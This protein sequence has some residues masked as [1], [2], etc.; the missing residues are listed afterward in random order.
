MEGSDPIVFKIYELPGLI[1][2]DMFSVLSNQMIILLP[3]LLGRHYL[4]SETG[5]RDLLFALL[6]GGVAYSIPALIEIR[7][8]PQLNT[9]IYGFFQHDFRQMMRNGGF[10]PIVFFPHALWL[11]FFFMGTAVAAAA[12]LRQE[13]R[14]QRVKY[15]FC[16]LYLLAVLVLSKSLASQ[17]Y[18]I[19]LVPLV[20]VANTRVQ[21]ALAIVLALLA[22][23]YPMLR[24]LG[25]IPL[26]AIL[27]QAEAVSPDRAQSLGYRFRN[28]EQLLDRARDKW[29]FGW[30][31]WGRN[32]VRH[33]ETGQ[34]LSIP[35]G[36]WIISFGS[37][38]WLGY[39][40]E[41][42]LLATALCLLGWRVLPGRAAVASALA[43]PVALLLA[44]TMVDMLLNDTLVPLTWLVA[45][46]V[47]GHA[48]TLRPKSKAERW[49]TGR[50]QQPVMGSLDEKPEKRTIL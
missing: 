23:T 4:A 26:D 44:I 34:I 24:N 42:G 33:D 7:L 8:S 46:A 35:D 38:G 32:L 10:R 37:Y 49:R 39:L 16:L 19:L 41:M 12:L 36:R 47:L 3:F 21:V 48:E 27:A 1:W 45:G 6:L 29:L 18:A 30:G 2:R 11:A 31:G 13:A 5:L 25:L 15:L 14:E 20:L 50:K 43:G 9:W 28:E 22:V 17:L 40:S